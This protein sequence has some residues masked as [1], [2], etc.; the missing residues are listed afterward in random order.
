VARSLV[1]G[2]AADAGRLAVLRSIAA[3]GVPVVAEG[4]ERWPDVVAVGSTGVRHIQGFVMGR[5]CPL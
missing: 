4:A 3:L 1:G 2:C 5:P